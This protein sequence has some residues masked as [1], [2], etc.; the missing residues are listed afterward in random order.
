[1]SSTLPE[2][3]FRMWTGPASAAKRFGLPRCAV[4]EEC[5]IDTRPGGKMRADSRNLDGSPYSMLGAVVEVVP[6]RLMALRSESPLAAFTRTTPTD[7]GAAWGCVNR[8]TS[9][10]EARGDQ[11]DS[12]GSARPLRRRPEGRHAGGVRVRLGREPR[13]LEEGISHAHPSS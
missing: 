9:E 6:P 1:M 13:H 4:N 8:A 5:E 2:T 3:V 11:G 12:R 10:E 7:W